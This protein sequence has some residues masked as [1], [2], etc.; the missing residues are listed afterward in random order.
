MIALFSRRTTATSND[1][2]LIREPN[3][4]ECGAAFTG[5]YGWAGYRVGSSCTNRGCTEYSPRVAGEQGPTDTT[6]HEV[7]TATHN[8]IRCTC[9][10]AFD[11][12]SPTA[13]L[14]AMS[15]HVGAVRVTCHQLD[16]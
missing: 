13:S 9:G 16:S 2:A 3:C 7:A 11:F 5:I 12:G 6:T 4:S 8:E 15:D 1:G 14:R 10:R